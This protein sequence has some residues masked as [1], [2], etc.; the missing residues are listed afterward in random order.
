MGLILLTQRVSM[1]INY[2]LT[3]RHPP[4]RDV[5][6]GNNHNR[7]GA[8]NAVE[9]E[10]RGSDQLLVNHCIQYHIYVY[11]YIHTY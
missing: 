8:F 3:T 2:M 5:D 11:I 1:Y 10:R 9:G 6:F 4:A 7:Y